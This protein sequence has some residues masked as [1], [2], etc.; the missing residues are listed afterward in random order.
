MLAPL[1]ATVAVVVLFVVVFPAVATTTVIVT[2]VTS[3]VA[4]TMRLFF[5]F[6][7]WIILLPSTNTMDKRI[8]LIGE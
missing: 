1:G 6:L 8:L 3:V 7:R 5:L 2:N 4:F